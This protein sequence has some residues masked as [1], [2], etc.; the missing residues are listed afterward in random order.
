MVSLNFKYA[1]A[2][3]VHPSV[4]IQMLK[5]AGK[6]ANCTIEI[7]KRLVRLLFETE[8]LEEFDFYANKLMNYKDCQETHLIQLIFFNN[9]L[10]QPEKAR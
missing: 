6:K 5:K 9:R 4:Q 7:L 2:P 3:Q 8:Q 10:K 1:D